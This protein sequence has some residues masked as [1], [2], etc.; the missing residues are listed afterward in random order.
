M[1]MISL[2]S[3]CGGMDLGF[4]QAGFNT[5]F[6]NDID[7]AAKKVW[8]NNFDIPMTTGDIRDITNFPK[9]SVVIGGFPC[10]DFSK[11]GKQAGFKSSRGN[12]YKQ[13]LRVVHTV[14]PKLFIMENVPGF[15]TQGGLERIKRAAQPY[16][17]RYKVLNA[18]DY[19]VPQRRKRVF[20]IGS[21]EKLIFRWPTKSSMV[22]VREALT[23]VP[24]SKYSKAKRLD[25][26]QGQRILPWNGVSPTI[27]AEHHGNIEFH[28]DNHRR[29]SVRECARLQTFPDNFTFDSVSM[30][31]A[32]RLIGNAVPVEMAR[33]I[34]KGLLS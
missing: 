11:A 8:D 21:R 16:W 33:Q 1:E 14:K 34:A 13:F 4:K 31:V 28:P 2:F 10:Q 19:G 5:V 25:K 9:A 7:S 22:T 29:L 24:D 23:D 32:Y 18:A 15:L 3:G 6:A 17:I 30:S 27:R 20:F 12:L 26:G